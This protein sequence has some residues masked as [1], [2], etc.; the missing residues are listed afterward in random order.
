MYRLIILVIFN[1]VISSSI[2]YAH[3]D[4]WIRLPD[5]TEARE[6]YEKAL[7]LFIRARYDSSRVL[8]EKAGVIYEK[9]K[10]WDRY[11]QCLNKIGKNYYKKSEWD[12]AVSVLNRSLSIGLEKVGKESLEV[13]ETY[14]ILGMVCFDMD[15][16]NKAADYY[17]KSLSIR[18]MK[19]G[20]KNKY[21]A[22]CYHRIGIVHLYKSEY[23]KA[24]EYYQKALAI[25]LEV[26]GENDPAI[27]SSYIS[28]SHCVDSFTGDYHSPVELRKKALLISLSSF[29]EKHPEVARCYHS[30]ANSYYSTGEYEA[31]LQ[32][33]RK[34]LSIELELLG[35]K[36]LSVANEYDAIGSN[37]YYKGDYNTAI[38]YHRKSLSIFLSLFRRENAYA[39]ALYKALG[40]DYAGKQEYEEALKYSQ[41]SL[42]INTKVLGES[43]HSITGNLDCIAEIY[44]KKGEHDK[45]LEYFQ[46]GLSLRSMILGENS[47]EFAYNYNRIGQV[48]EKKGDYDSSFQFYQK[49]ISLLSKI[50]KPGE[51]NPFLSEAYMGIGNISLSKENYTD[52]LE[53]Y[54]NSIIALA[55]GFQDTNI[56]AN[57]PLDGISD[58][59]MMVDALKSKAQA[60]VNFFAVQSKNPKDIKTAL[61]I[62]ELAAKLIHKI[63]NSY[64]SEN[65]QLK[66]LERAFD[67]N[68]QAIAIAIRLYKE[69]RRNEYIEKAF[70]FSERS[71]AALLTQSLSE[72]DA[73]KIAGI[74][75]DMLE[76]EKDIRLDQS[77]YEKR[78]FEEKGKGKLASASKI[79]LWQNRLF[80]S[81]RKNDSLARQFETRYP[82][83]FNLKYRDFI[84][85]PDELR[86][87]ILHKNDVIVEYFL[88]DSVV[89]IFTLTKQ[90]LHFTTITIDTAFDRHI[91]SMREGLIKR[92]YIQYTESAY[93]LY[94]MLIEPI[95]T[96]IRG[97]NLI[98]IPDGILGYIPFEALLTKKADE[99]SKDYRQLAYLIKDHR[100]AY[101][102]SSTLLYENMTKGRH[103]TGGRY[104]GFAPVTFK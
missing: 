66:L 16:V 57:P 28:V 22:D 14:Y 13:A 12:S 82:E 79:A 54:Q 42:A 30:L 86:K 53:N 50:L 88:G 81:R 69:T 43:H 25:R 58:E 46:K 59:S 87:K 76:E 64:Q 83:Y 38:E 23:S 19:L 56:Y 89:Y 100:I 92:N 8:F 78:L 68:K 60:L 77:R 103:K 45:A 37:Y 80:D 35:E 95:R 11:V 71:K 32:Y 4:E 20:E 41:K 75:D 24:L 49:A 104:V 93:G 15:E 3:D 44:L 48:Y 52:A 101:G 98:I 1:S 97:K 72:S 10:I 47:S 74:P 55:E 65:S 67:I 5:T 9:E 29:G 91:R 94:R 33:C 2:L 36:N 61:S 70:C 73:K 99:R 27:A 85:L 63:R 18:L 31:S 84:A 39:A 51:K 62:Y 17:Q 21:V 96:R 26:L 6:S 34:A 90:N 7:E 102:Y 40:N